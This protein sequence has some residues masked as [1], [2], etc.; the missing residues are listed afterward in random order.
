MLLYFDSVDKAGHDGGPDSE[1][2]RKFYSGGKCLSNLAQRVILH[3][4]YF[5]HCTLRIFIIPDSQVTEALHKIDDVIGELMDGLYRLN[6]HKCLNI[7][8]TSDHG[9][10]KYPIFRNGVFCIP[11]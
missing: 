3:E 6:M 10:S 7:I 11:L 1:Q 8:I 5:V 9:K 2:V 4:Y